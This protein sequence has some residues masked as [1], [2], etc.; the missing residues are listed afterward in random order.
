MKQIRISESQL[1]K[2][3]SESVTR[4]IGEIS[5]DYNPG[6][7]KSDVIRESVK[8]EIYGKLKAALREPLY[9]AA[10]SFSNNLRSS[11]DESMGDVKGMLSGI[12][13]EL[14]E[15]WRPKLWG[16]REKYTIQ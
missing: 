1:R 6:R 16:E 10:E 12:V 3:V 8:D 11:Y 2:V 13:D 5:G 15:G 9:A 4:V 14:F 7:L